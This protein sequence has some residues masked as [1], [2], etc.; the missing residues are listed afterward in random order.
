M[1]RS[2]ADLSE[3]YVNLAGRV[4]VSGTPVEVSSVGLTAPCQE[5]YPSRALLSA[6]QGAEVGMTMAS[7]SH[8][9]EGAGWGINLVADQARKAGYSQRA[10]F[11]QRQH[12][13]MGLDAADNSMG[14]RV[15]RTLPIE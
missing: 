3:V 14:Q 6:F 13:S 5:I 12:H 1:K 10:V 7:D 8:V 15:S 2:T 11:R 4:V 9:P